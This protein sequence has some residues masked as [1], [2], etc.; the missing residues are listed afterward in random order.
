MS[1]IAIIILVVAGL[2]ALSAFLVYLIKDTRRCNRR[3]SLRTLKLQKIAYYIKTDDEQMIKDIDEI[4]RR[5][6]NI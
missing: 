4:D 1:T 3:E 6:N 5:M 2:G